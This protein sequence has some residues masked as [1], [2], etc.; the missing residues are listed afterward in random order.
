MRGELEKFGAED[1]GKAADR[2]Y[3]PDGGRPARL[4]SPAS[5][6]LGAQCPPGWEH[7]VHPAMP[8][9]SLSQDPGPVCRPPRIQQRYR[10]LLRKFAISSKRLKTRGP[11]FELDLCGTVSSN[12]LPSRGESHEINALGSAALDGDTRLGIS[13]SLRRVKNIQPPRPS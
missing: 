12:P 7:N 2:P 4:R 9:M 6:S 1:Q 3:R 8:P 13:P 5:R 11:R 10:T